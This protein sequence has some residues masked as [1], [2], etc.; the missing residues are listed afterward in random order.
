MTTQ[1]K[2]KKPKIISRVV[3]DITSVGIFCLRGSYSV[4]DRHKS[5]L[6][7]GRL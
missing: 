4:V 1:H 3:V 6:L 7:H 2:T 5:L